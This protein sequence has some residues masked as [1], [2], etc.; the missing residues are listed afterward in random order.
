MLEITEFVKEIRRVEVVHVLYCVVIFEGKEREISAV[1]TED[2]YETAFY[3]NF[4]IAGISD[5]DL[6][7]LEIEMLHKLEND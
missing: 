4:G 2:E 1:V 5:E 3:W 7:N 6:D